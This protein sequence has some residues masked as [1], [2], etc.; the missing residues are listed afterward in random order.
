LKIVL[1]LD[2]IYLPSFGGGIKANRLLLEGFARNGHE[3]LALTRALTRS[4]DGPNS[5]QAFFDEMAS[6]A[7]TVRTPDAD[8]FAYEHEGVRVESLDFGDRDASG[9]YIDR[10]IRETDPDWILVADDKRRTMLEAAMRFDEGRAIPIVQTIMQLPFGPLSVQR[11]ARQSELMRKV[12][13]I[14]VISRYLQDYIATHGG[15]HSHLVRLPVYGSGPFRELGRFY[16]GYVT[17]INPCELK[18][19]S[20]FL[21]LARRFPDTAFAAVPTWGADDRVLQEL[22]SLTNVRILPPEDDIERILERTRILLV[23]SLWPETFGYVVPDAMLRGIP[24]IASNVGGLPEAKLGV[25]YL[26]PV[27]PAERQG[28]TYVC[29]PQ[30][31]GPWAEALRVLLADRQEYTRCARDSRSAALEFLPSTSVSRFEALLGDLD[32][33][34]HG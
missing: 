32:G 8:V 33:L 34:R 16:A 11:N 27:I 29:P 4:P 12:P 30:D 28:K 14:A 18:G 5:R 22:R 6:R 7:K 10:R 25:D 21:E 17:M 19:L 2:E 3:C 15:L 13:G 9:A 31:V 23:P 1:L 20:I 26:L 24:V